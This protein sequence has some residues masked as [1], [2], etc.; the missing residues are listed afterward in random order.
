VFVL[1]LV[2][3]LMGANALLEVLNLRESDCACDPRRVQ[4]S[5]F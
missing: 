5:K 1:V 4:S 3:A 2:L